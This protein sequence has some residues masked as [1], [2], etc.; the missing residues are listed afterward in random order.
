MTDPIA[1]LVAYHAARLANA[2][3]YGGRVPGAD[4]DVDPGRTLLL[5]YAGDPGAF[6]G[7]NQRYGDVRVHAFAYGNDDLAA[8]QLHREVLAGFKA[9][10]RAVHKGVLL[11]WARPAGGTGQGEDADTGW[12]LVRSTWIV[13]TA[14]VPIT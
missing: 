13:L 3:V 8:L 7:G 1:A 9:L 10:S 6:G 11:H 4:H 2:S 14:E 12:P 5:R